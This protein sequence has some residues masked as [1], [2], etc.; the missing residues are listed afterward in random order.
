MRT[1]AYYG[2][3]DGCEHAPSCLTCPFETCKLEEGRQEVSRRLPAPAVGPV[4]CAK[5][6]R[7]A[8]IL[9]LAQ[10][11]VDYARIAERCGVDLRTVQRVLRLARLRELDVRA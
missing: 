10:F 6:R 11:G 9:R 1:P 7:N 8:G 3:D 2:R 4:A 5:C